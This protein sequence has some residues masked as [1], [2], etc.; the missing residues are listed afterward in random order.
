MHDPLAK[1]GLFD[2]QGA[3]ILRRDQQRFH[4]ADG[5]NVDKRRLPRQLPDFGDKLT[6]SL[7]HDRRG[8]SQRVP[9]GDADRALDQHIHAR[10]DVS[11]HEQR[12]AGCVAPY[13]AEPAKPIDFLRRKLWE[14]ML[15]AGINRRHVEP[16]CQ[17]T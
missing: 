14:H 7:L 12:I 17:T 8:V 2:H 11:R 6:R 10:R 15:V 9:S 4:I 16:F 13:L 5:V 3:Q 1:F